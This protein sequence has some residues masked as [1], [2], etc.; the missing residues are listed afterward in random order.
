M[1][2]PIVL[3]TQL[4]SSAVPSNSSAL[5]ATITIL[6]ANLRLCNLLG[7]SKN[8]HLIMIPFPSQLTH[9]KISSNTVLNRLG[10]KDHLV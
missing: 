2:S 10:I 6:S 8:D 4:K 9:L 5:L 7:L 1:F 3:L